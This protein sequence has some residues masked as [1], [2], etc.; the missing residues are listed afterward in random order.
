MLKTKPVITLMSRKSRLENADSLVLLS[1]ATSFCGVAIIEDLQK[2]FRL[3]LTDVQETE[4]CH[5]FV[6]WD[7]RDPSFPSGLMDGVWAIC[8]LARAGHRGRKRDSQYVVDQ[9]MVNILGLRNMLFAAAEAGVKKFVYASSIEVLE[10]GSERSFYDEETPSCPRLSDYS[11]SKYLGECL[12]SAFAC[13]VSMEFI[14]LR[15]ALVLSRE[16]EWKRPGDEHLMH[17]DR[18]VADRDVAQAVRMA[19]HSAPLESNF[20]VFHIVGDYPAGRWTCNKAK[21]KI[22]FQPKDNFSELWRNL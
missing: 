16:I 15:I 6:Q 7:L 11:M 3:R 10:G 21:E 22:G 2:S 5:E 4:S 17:R 20:E 12:C 14:V 1:G 9:Y 18:I 19:L 13:N 8:H